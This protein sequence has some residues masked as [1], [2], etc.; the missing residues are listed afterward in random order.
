MKYGVELRGAKWLDE[1][2][3]RHYPDVVQDKNYDFIIGHAPYMANGCI[4]LTKLY[5]N[6]KRVIK[7]QSSCSMHYPR[8]SKEILTMKCCWIG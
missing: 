2:R 5:R 4:N 8:M 7:R 3:L 1:D 6:K